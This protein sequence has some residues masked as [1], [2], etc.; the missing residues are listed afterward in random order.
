MEEPFPAVQDR[1]KCLPSSREEIQGE[2]EKKAREKVTCISDHHHG[3]GSS[4]WGRGANN[5]ILL[6]DWRL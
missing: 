5:K 6:T 4:G 3:V 2:S 1:E